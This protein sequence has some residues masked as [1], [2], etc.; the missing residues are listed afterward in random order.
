[1]RSHDNIYLV[2]I[3]V[4]GRSHPA[5]QKVEL[6]TVRPVTKAV[7][8][9]VTNV[10]EPGEVTLSTLQPQEEVA[11]TATLMDRGR[12]SSL[13]GDPTFPID[14]T[15]DLT[16]VSRRQWDRMAVVAEHAG[17]GALDGHRRGYAFKLHARDRSSRKMLPTTMPAMWGCTFGPR[18]PT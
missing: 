4:D 15:A 18:P 9:E 12:H 17:D 16:N 7:R 6:P 14:L 11:V 10:E 8:V 1:M 3:Q 2:T 5:L 13:T